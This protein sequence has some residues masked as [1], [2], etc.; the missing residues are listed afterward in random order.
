MVLITGCAGYIAT[1]LA[2][3][4]LKIETGVRGLIL[5]QQTG[6]MEELVKAGLELYVGDVRKKCDLE[7]AVDGVDIVYHLT[8]GHSTVE[9]MRETYVEGT[10]NLLE[11]C[12]IYGVEKVILASSGAVYGNCLDELILEDHPWNCDHPF[13]EINCEMEEVIRY[14]YEQEC[15][16]V[17]TL[18]IAEVY[19]KDKFNFFQKKITE[20]TQVAGSPNTYNSRIFIGDLVQ[21]LIMAPSKLEVGEAY[22]VSDNYAA[23]LQEFYEKLGMAIPKWVDVA[24]LPIRV[25]RSIH[26]L[27]ANSIRMSNEKLMSRLSYSLVLP[28]YKEGIAYCRQQ[29][30]V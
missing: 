5:P 2:K 9:R 20:Q 13:S 4:L 22:N 16:G 14:F 28:T 27:R 6:Q 19:G 29:M 17:I 23:T 1:H 12:N 8:G 21:I 24:L 3:E 15:L 10:R 7:P 30:D 26:G 25:Q 18:R 11:L